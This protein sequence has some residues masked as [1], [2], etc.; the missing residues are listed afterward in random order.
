LGKTVEISVYGGSALLLTYDWRHP[1]RDLDAVFENDKTLV[2]ELAAD[3]AAER[4][5]DK[6]WLNDGVKGFLSQIDGAPGSKQLFGTY[7]S[8]AQPGLRVLVAAPVYLFAMKCRAMRLGG[9]SETSDVEDIKHLSISLGITT[10]AQAIEIV[11]S[12]YPGRIIEAKTQFGIEEIFSD[13]SD[14]GQDR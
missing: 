2:R 10:A 1:T 13:R 9:A 11:A 6:D 14:G 4:G 8:E 5:W 3:I 7:P 12:F